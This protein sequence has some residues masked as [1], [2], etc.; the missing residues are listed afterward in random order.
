MRTKTSLLGGAA[1][2]V[3]LAAMAAAPV[4]AKTVKKVSETQQ[5]IDDLRQELQTLKDRLDEQT[6]INQQAKAQVQ[7]AEAD[8]AAAKAAAA[9]SAA[10]LKTAQAQI[11]QQ[12]PA[13]IDTRVNTAVA[14]NKPKTDKIYVKGVSITMGGFLEAA[15]IYRDHDQTADIGSSYG[16]IPFANDRAGHTAE[17]RFTA[18]QSRYSLLAQGDVNK[19]TV[20]SFYGEFDFLGAAQTANS[21]ESNSYQPR[22]RVVYGTIDWNKSGWHILGGQNWSLVTLQNNGISPRSEV[23]PPQIDAQYVPGF[24][25]ARQPGFRVV[26]DFNKEWWVGVSVEN[27]QTT[28]SANGVGSGQSGG[29]ASGV[30]LTSSQAPTSQFFNG[31]NYSLNPYP[32]V[33]GKVAWEKKL[34]DQKVHIEGFGIMRTFVSRVNYNAAA[35]TSLGVTAGNQTNTFTAGG[36]GGSISIYDVVPKHLDLQASVMVGNGIGRYG[37]SQLADVTARPDGTLVGIPETM[38]LAGGT[39]HANPK[40]DLYVFAGA[41]TENS[42]L[43][44]INATTVVGYGTLPGSN[45]SGCLV[46]GG[47]CS[48]LNKTVD[49]VTGGLWWKFYQGSFGRAQW[50]LQYSYTE[51]KAFADAG[52]LAPLA[53]EN[54][55]FTS[56]RF[57]PF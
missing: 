27:P 1:V 51:R 32:D 9:Q 13:E 28:I 39:F 22:T 55:V 44:N 38:W 3:M 20:A 35:A 48:A 10:D 8:A 4:Q 57:Y 52:G 26:K 6:Q 18:R 24:A 23:T 36:G 12:I 25:W 17:T 41:E 34:G 14:A 47:S 46:E 5:Q 49:Q 7:S 11:I 43:Y 40:L 31:T 16:K 33:I 19:D 30:T 42:K 2:G 53:K 50:G 54:M 15:S 45:N 37:S 56:F 29:V 21:N